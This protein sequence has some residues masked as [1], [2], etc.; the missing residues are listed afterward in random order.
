VT[1]EPFLPALS[2]GVAVDAAAINGVTNQAFLL[3]DGAVQFTVEFRSAVSAFANSLGFYIVGLD[4]TIGDV[5]IL[6]ANTLGVSP[7]TQ[8][9]LPIP[10]GQQI[11]FFLI[12]DGFDVYGALPDDL[13]FRSPG[14][15]NPADLDLGLPPTLFSASRGALTA[16]PVFHSF[17]TLNSSDATQVLSG[18]SPDGRELRIGFEDLPTVSGDNDFQDAIVAVRVDS[19][20]SLVL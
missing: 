13:S 11:G 1:F 18:V 5:G 9:G 4:G 2:E 3:G 20:G 17:A 16:A 12:Q 14:T 10:E 15:A 6:F 8:I 7:G 19:D